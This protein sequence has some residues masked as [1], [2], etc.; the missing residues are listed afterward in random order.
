[1]INAFPMASTGWIYQWRENARKSSLSSESNVAEK[2]VEV[3][4][5]KFLQA[6][7]CIRELSAP[8]GAAFRPPRREQ[9][10]GFGI[11]SQSCGASDIE[12]P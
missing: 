6:A 8:G 7:Q 4:A 10:K 3:K 2:T 12:A 9:A 5:L 1:M 11:F